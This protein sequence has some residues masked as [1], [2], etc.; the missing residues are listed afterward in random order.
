MKMYGAIDT[1]LH[2]LLISALGADELSAS[3]PDHFTLS[4]HW[5]GGWVSL[6]DCMETWQREKSLPSLGI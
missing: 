3:I 6:G 4:I 2:G 1:W 5:I